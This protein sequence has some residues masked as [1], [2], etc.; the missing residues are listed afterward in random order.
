MDKNYSQKG[1]TLLEL[2]I[3]IFIISVGVLAI[4]SVITKYSQQ[5]GSIRESLV[6]SYLGQEGVEIVKNIR[7]TNWVNGR[8]WNYGLTSC[9]SGCEADY[10]STSLASSSSRYLYLDN[11][12][13]FYQYTPG[14]GGGAVTPYQRKITVTNPGTDEIDIQVDVTWKT[15]TI[16]VKENLYNWKP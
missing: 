10:A 9:S 8:D 7:D 1:F 11:D 3:S 6:A 16:T 12:T 4:F 15:Y 13:G 5:T 2:M 14:S